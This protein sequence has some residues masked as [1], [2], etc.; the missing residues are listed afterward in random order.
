MSIDNF[1]KPRALRGRAT[2]GFISIN[3]SG[4]RTGSSDF[5]ARQ[6][7]TT[8]SK[9]GRI[10][11][12]NQPEGYNPAQQ[13]IKPGQSQTELNNQSSSLLH[14]NLS[15]KHLPLLQSK[16]GKSRRKLPKANWRKRTSRWIKRISIVLVVFIII[17]GGFLVSKSYL[18]FHQ[19]FRGGGSTLQ[20]ST[21]GRI[22]ILLLGI[23]GVG[24]DGPDLTDTILIASIDPVN[25]KAALLSIPRDLWVKMPNDYV[26][27][28]QKINA[29]YEAGKYS[30][31]GRE[32]QSNSNQ[33]AI[34]AGFKS[35]DQV[36]NQVFGVPINYNVLV[37]FQ[38]FQQAINSVGGISINVPTELYDPT[39]AWQN[40]WNPVL[41]MPGLQTMNGAKALL[42]VRSRETSSDFARTQRQRAVMLALKTKSLTLGTLS[43]P[44]KI[45]SLVSA[46]GDNVRTDL[47]LSDAE[48]LYG[49]IKKIDNSNISSIGLADPPNNFVT[50]GNISGL[51]VVEPVAGEF[52]YN[53]IQA[54]L[55]TVL[56]DGNLVKENA[57]IMVLN[58]TTTPGLANK[59]AA[60]LEASGYTVTSMSDAPKQDY[61]QTTVVDLT[62]GK[63][64]YTDQDLE[65]RFHVN[66]VNQLPDNTI[67]PKSAN[68]VIIVGED[69]ATIN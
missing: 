66:V 28:Y 31:L 36:V 56:R 24:H 19:V 6:P 32:D 54:Y 53:A 2:D 42:Y 30:Y 23:G 41:A 11:D 34:K 69:E 64:K 57:N 55:R 65:K 38:A 44:L 68:F 18:K 59:V 4:T 35:V 15:A 16:D 22:N 26:G 29:A 67:Q 52:D 3:T 8:Q 21:A 9:T 13:L 50:T 60:Q 46:F 37:D 39:M 63:D 40:N 51:S 49:I 47:S 33:K 61:T 27:N 43:N 5:V 1:K 14:K 7:I 48:T 10:G 58:G 25:N 12:F 62:G 20:S 45:S 17:V